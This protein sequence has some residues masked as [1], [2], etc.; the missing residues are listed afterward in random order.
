V[1]GGGQLHLLGTKLAAQQDR[2]RAGRRALTN[3][4][5]CF[6]ASPAPTSNSGRL[7]ACSAQALA[8]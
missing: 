3:S 8:S 6:S 1:Q 4:S 5:I 2:Q 7:N